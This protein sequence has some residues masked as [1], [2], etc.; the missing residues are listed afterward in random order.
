MDRN[1]GLDLL[2]LCR[3]YSGRESE[4]WQ[5]AKIEDRNLPSTSLYL[6]GLNLLIK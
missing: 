6:V 3:E 4:N 1:I 2:K 5:F